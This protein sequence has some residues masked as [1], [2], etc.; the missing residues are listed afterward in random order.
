MIKK[1]K[2]QI[3]VLLLIA[4]VIVVVAAVLL[5]SA[6]NRSSYGDFVV[7]DEVVWAPTGLRLEAVID[8]NKE[9]LSQYNIDLEIVNEDDFYFDGQTWSAVLISDDGIPYS[10]LIDKEFIV[11]ISGVDTDSE[12]VYE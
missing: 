12:R 10:V 7:G 8:N 2:M 6:M 11:T 1:D 9:I 3:I 5:R 4:I